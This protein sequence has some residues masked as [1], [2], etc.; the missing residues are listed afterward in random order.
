VFSDGSGSQSFQEM[1]DAERA[2][3]VSARSGSGL[4]DMLYRE[5]A[6]KMEGKP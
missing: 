3:Q 1:L 6:R 2:R 5:L 4:G